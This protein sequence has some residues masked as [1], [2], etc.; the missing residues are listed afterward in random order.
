MKDQ[1][2]ILVKAIDEIFQSVP[3][4][5]SYET[6]MVVNDLL[7]GQNA[8]GSVTVHLRDLRI[9]FTPKTTTERTSK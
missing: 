8:S 7:V 1:T 2:D 4:S 9:T 5:K 3:I 6:T